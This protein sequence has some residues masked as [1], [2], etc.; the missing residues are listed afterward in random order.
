MGV[1]IVTDTSCDLPSDLEAEL[2]AAGTQMIPFLYHFGQEACLDKTISMAEFLERAQQQWPT[3]AAPSA[4]AFAKALQRIVEAGH[5]A[6]CI[7]ITGRHSATYHTAALAAEEFEADQV[8]VVDSR[9][10]SLAQGLLVLAAV[11]AAQA[12]AT[13]QEIVSRVEDLKRRICFYFALDTLDYLVKGGR[14]S[15][16]VG[17]LANLLRLRPILTLDDGE[18]TL[19]EKPRQRSAAK[20]RL[21]ALAQGCLPAQTIGI[22][23]VACASEA[24]ELAEEIS[25][26]S[27]VPLGQIPIAETGTALATHSGP[28]ALGVVV[29]PRG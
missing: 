20:A 8:Q 6:L 18:L 11:R 28:G 5:Q 27:G 25:R 1:R 23:H 12:G 26:V 22:M 13:L 4:G 9:S 3:T 14:A 29:V 17:I 15:R 24:A 16:L 21:I 10:L 7:T 19:I 2:L